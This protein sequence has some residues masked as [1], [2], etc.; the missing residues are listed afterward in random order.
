MSQPDSVVQWIIYGVNW[1]EEMNQ[2]VVNGYTV[3]YSIVMIRKYFIIEKQ[4]PWKEVNWIAVYHLKYSY[5]IDRKVINFT[6]SNTN[7]RITNNKDNHSN[8]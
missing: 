7:I 3:C 5:V 6:A 8:K 1:L 4:T 2:G